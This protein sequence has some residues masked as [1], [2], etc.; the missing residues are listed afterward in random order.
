MLGKRRPYGQSAGA[1]AIAFAASSAFP[2]FARYQAAGA[3]FFSLTRAD[4]SPGQ[5]RAAAL[6]AAVV[7]DGGQHV[8][9]AARER[10]IDRELAGVGEVIAGHG[11][12]A[13]DVVDLED[14]VHEVVDGEA[15]VAEPL[16]QPAVGAGHL[17]PEAVHLGQRLGDVGRRRR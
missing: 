6:D 8:L 14:Q 10:E 9:A 13:A 1:L 16:D 5:G 7:A 17:A 11:V 12:D 3:S 4:I 2:A 15:A